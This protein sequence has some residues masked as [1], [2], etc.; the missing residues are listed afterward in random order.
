MRG[1]KTDEK[2]V[3]V[4]ISLREEQKCK[5]IKRITKMQIPLRKEQKC[6]PTE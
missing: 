3:W 1:P 6:N 4:Q 5:L 2:S